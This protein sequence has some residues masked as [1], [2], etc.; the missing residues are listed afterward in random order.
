MEPRKCLRCGGTRLEP[1]AIQSTGR[2]YFRPTNS[3]F[4]TF[5]TANVRVKS[6]MCLDC[7][8]VELVGD[9]KK[10]GALAGRASAN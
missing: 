8:T 5:G 3:S 2:I 6:N 1:G 9:I 10:A 7:G 4:W